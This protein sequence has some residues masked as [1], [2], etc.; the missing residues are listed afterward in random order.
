M[1]PKLGGILFFPSKMVKITEKVYLGNAKDAQDVNNLVSVGINA[2][3]N[4][5]YEI[6]SN[7]VCPEGFQLVRS[8]LFDFDV[9]NSH[10]SLYAA[11]FQLDNLIKSGHTVLVHC[12]QG[13][14]RS[15]MIVMAYLYAK[16]L[17]GKLD[18]AEIIPADSDFGLDEGATGIYKHIQG[19]R[20]I[21]CL[22]YRRLAEFN[23]LDWN[24]ITKTICNK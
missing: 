8:P 6:P 3:L 17:G 15:P 14:S 21:V 24:F 20:E 23:A 4:V 10:S 5:A 18:I 22:H 19:K 12:Q 9:D 2:I 1:E 13:I 16:L 11:I 7:Q